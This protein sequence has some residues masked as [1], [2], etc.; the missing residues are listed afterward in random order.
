MFISSSIVK[1]I[2]NFD[3]DVSGCV[4]NCIIKDIQKRV[5]E[6]RRESL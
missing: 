4:P 2:A 5:E 6:S 3:G 1:Q